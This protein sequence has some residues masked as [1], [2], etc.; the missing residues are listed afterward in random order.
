M[1]E[2]SSGHTC[3]PPLLTSVGLHPGAGYRMEPVS[4]LRLN[5]PA[6]WQR[7]SQDCCSQRLL[8]ENTS[9]PCRN[10]GSSGFWSRQSCFKQL[11]ATQGLSLWSGAVLSHCKRALRKWIIKH[12]ALV[13]CKTLGL[14]RSA[15]SSRK[16]QKFH[17]PVREGIPTHAQANLVFFPL[18]LQMVKALLF[19]FPLSCW[20]L[21]PSIIRLSLF[22]LFSEV[23]VAWPPS[24]SPARQEPFQQEAEASL[25]KA[26]VTFEHAVVFCSSWSNPDVSHLGC[27]LIIF[28]CKGHIITTAWSLPSFSWSLSEWALRKCQKRDLWN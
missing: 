8:S 26:V 5:L 23:C 1:P 4:S 12:E 3:R 2:H 6:L 14:S 13:L 9:L 18:P 28:L 25:P 10:Q 27:R 24:H 19:T 11:E 16:R 17:G 22:F 7:I 15:C 21:G 20:F